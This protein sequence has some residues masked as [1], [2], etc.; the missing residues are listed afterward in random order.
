MVLLQLW[1]VNSTEAVSRGL[2]VRGWGSG[3]RDLVMWPG[4]SG[5]SGRSRVD[6]LHLDDDLALPHGDNGQL[7]RDLLKHCTGAVAKLVTV[8]LEEIPARNRNAVVVTG[9]FY[10]FCSLYD[11]RKKKKLAKETQTY[12]SY[13][14]CKTM[15]KAEIPRDG[16]NRNSLIQGNTIWR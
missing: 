8:A 14:F 13:I 12:C 2:S 7:V 6:L 1:I 15:F 3:T 9:V 16:R 11:K 5:R 10:T 4:R